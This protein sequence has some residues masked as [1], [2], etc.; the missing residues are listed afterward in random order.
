MHHGNGTEAIFDDVADV[1]YLSTHEWPQYPG[2][3]AAEYAGRG[4]GTGATVNVPLPAGTG[5]DAYLAAYRGRIRPA[6][7]A[8]APDVI[9]VSAGFDAHRD[10]PLGGLELVDETYAELTRDLLAITPRVTAVL[11][12]GYDL[13]A[14]ARSSVRV[15]QTLLGD[16]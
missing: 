8:F 2:T 6:L 1:L 10:D 15:L 4:R 7:V 13:D 16:A 12:G 5:P 14:I 9:L 11:E 3:G